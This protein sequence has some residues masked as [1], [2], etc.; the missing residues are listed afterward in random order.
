MLQSGWGLFPSGLK[1][2]IS[3]GS[4]LCPESAAHLAL[5]SSKLHPA[6]PRSRGRRE[7]S[8][9]GARGVARSAPAA[10]THTSGWQTG[11]IPAVH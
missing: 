6:R 2:L 3:T 4:W 7:Q 8:L 11:H 10:G 1:K 5:L 9:T